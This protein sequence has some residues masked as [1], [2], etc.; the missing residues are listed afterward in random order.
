MISPGYIASDMSTGSEGGKAWE[1][2]WMKRTPVGR[3]GLPSEIG[4]MLTFLAS[5]KAT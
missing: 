5:D 4:D 3:F 1:S 2:E